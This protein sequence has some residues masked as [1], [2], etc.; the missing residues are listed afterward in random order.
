MYIFASPLGKRDFGCMFFL[1]LVGGGSSTDLMA[2]LYGL[3]RLLL[4]S[5]IIMFFMAEYANKKRA[6]SN[7]KIINTLQKLP[8]PM[9]QTNIASQ[10][11][12]LKLKCSVAD[13]KWTV[14]EVRVS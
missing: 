13:L 11:P 9:F 10:V 3:N 12:G 14:R 1:Y 2:S 8:Y 4:P 5:N 6:N 7:K